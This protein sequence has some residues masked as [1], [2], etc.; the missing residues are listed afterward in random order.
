MS[1]F[2]K[3]P[4]NE[5]VK[6]TLKYDHAEDYEDKKY[7]KKKRLGCEEGLIQPLGVTLA[8]ALNTYGA[9]KGDSF[10]VTKK[11]IGDKTV[12]DCLPIEKSQ[13]SQSQQGPDWDNIARGKVRHA[14][15]LEAFKNGFELTESTVSLVEAWVSY[16]MSGHA[17]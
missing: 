17:S 2:I 8:N 16:V 15:A 12:F 14:F 13:Q 5:A 10:M 9:K 3:F 4:L 1:E 6:I 11:K 7:G